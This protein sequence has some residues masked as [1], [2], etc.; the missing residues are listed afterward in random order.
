[1]GQGLNG[2]PTQHSWVA[3]LKLGIPL[4]TSFVYVVLGTN[5]YSCMLPYLCNLFFTEQQPQ[6]PSLATSPAPNS[7]THLVQCSHSGREE[8]DRNALSWFQSA[9]KG[10][11]GELKGASN[12]LLVGGCLVW[13][14]MS[15]NRKIVVF[16]SFSQ[17]APR[18]PGQSSRW[19]WGITA[20]EA[21][22]TYL[23]CRRQQLGLSSV[24]KK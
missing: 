18:K 6:S 5:R 16:Y 8:G 4:G 10:S 11:S 19:L 22:N 17:T 1:M 23:P 24:R 3:I 9:V 20:G 2:P 12:T 15:G 14:D 21:P 7:A 13:P